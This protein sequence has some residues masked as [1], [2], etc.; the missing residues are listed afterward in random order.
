MFARAATPR[1][2]TARCGCAVASCSR[3]APY[4]P[5]SLLLMRGISWWFCLCKQRKNMQVSV[6]IMNTIDHC[7]KVSNRLF[8]LPCQ[9]F[10][11]FGDIV[12]CF[13]KQRVIVKHV[14]SNCDIDEK[15]L[16]RQELSE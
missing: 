8:I 16:R 9:I 11:I 6:Y 1:D 4:H 2:M 3:F 14:K 10:Q 7:L 15:F 13:D 5:L 12:L